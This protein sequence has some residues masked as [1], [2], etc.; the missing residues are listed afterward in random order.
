M[1]ALVTQFGE[2]LTATLFVPW[3]T[4]VLHTDAS[5]YGSLLSAQAIGGLVGALA[6]GRLGARLEPK[7]LLV[8]AAVAFGLIDLVL[9]T[10]P[11]LFPFIGPALVGMV[12]VGCRRP[13]SGPRSRR[14]SRRSRRTA[15]EA[16]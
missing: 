13:Q 7:R 9:F 12:V 8:L 15:T 5:G 14:S 2:G 11:V 16:G 6:I 4:D 10:Y 3:A 1:F